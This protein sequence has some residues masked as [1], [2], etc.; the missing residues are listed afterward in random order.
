MI[1]TNQKTKAGPQANE[2][3]VY[4]KNVKEIKVPFPKAA[5]KTKVTINLVQ[6]LHDEMWRSS[7]S[8][9]AGS[10]GTSS[11]PSA[12][13][14]P[15][16]SRE[17][18]IVAAAEKARE[19]LLSEVERGNLSEASKQQVRAAPGR[20]N[21]MS[22]AQLK[23]QGITVLPL[24]RQRLNFEAFPPP[25][26]WHKISNG[27][28]QSDSKL[29]IVSAPGTVSGSSGNALYSGGGR[30][31]FTIN[32]NQRPSS[33]GSLIYSVINSTGSLKF[34]V[35]VT[36]TQILVKNE[37][38]ATIFSTSYTPT[39]GDIFQ[40]HI[41]DAF[42]LVKNGLQLFERSGAGPISF[43]CTYFASLTTPVVGASP[44]IAPPALIGDWGIAPAAPVVFSLQSGTGQL[45]AISPILVEYT[46]STIPGDHVLTAWLAQAQD[47]FQIQRAQAV[48]STP[49][50]RILGGRS[51]TLQPGQAIRPKTTYDNAQTL[52]LVSW[53]ILSG[54][55][56]LANGQF[57]A[58]TTPGVTVLRATSAAT[59]QIADLTI[60]VPAVIAVTPERDHFAGG[61]VVDWLTNLTSPAWSATAGS[62]NPG[63]GLWKAPQLPINSAR[64]TA[65]AGGV[66]VTRD[67][68]IVEKFPRSDFKLPWP[69][70]Y[71]K[72]VL[73]SEAE[74]GSR[75][76]RIKIR[77][78]RSFPVELLVDAVE[79]LNG[80]AGLGTIRDFWDRHHPG[81][82]FVME[83]PEEGIRF[84]AYS[85]SDIRWEHT[86]AGINIAFRV[87]QA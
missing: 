59:L 25:P 39:T 56:T 62:I 17:G 83:D 13:S 34:E 50:L 70:D 3:G 7:Y 32:D 43:P 11:L 33:S 40:I 28:I 41:G 4:V 75:T 8:V 44:A 2:H 31:E 15:H 35:H 67:V 76:S 73:V 29:S 78:K 18:A 77:A 38:A 74:D 64:I 68:E 58:P 9:T 66:V 51:I 23:P 71:A 22:R 24:D 5:G 53:S 14:T 81:V 63:T 27:A 48:L 61:E 45:S 46:G 54:G 6:D 10:G 55:G 84:V 49:S 82:R 30:I 85:D 26:L 12:L 47:S 79:D 16:R 42:R 72:R 86:G 1:T 37:V 57:T 60:T 36:A 21:A 19:F 52:G 20:I 87:K 80:R 69:V 65:T